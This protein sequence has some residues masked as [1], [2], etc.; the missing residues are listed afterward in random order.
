MAYIDPNGREGQGISTDSDGDLMIN[1]YGYGQSEGGFPVINGRRL[2]DK[3]AMWA[4]SQVDGRFLKARN[5]A[6]MATARAVWARRQ[7]ISAA[8][9]QG[10]NGSFFGRESMTRLDVGI[11][12]DGALRLTNYDNG[13]AIATVPSNAAPTP[14]RTAA[15]A[16]ASGTGNS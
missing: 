5:P 4:V 10:P 14:A 2:P 6:D 9:G 7:E 8:L 15:P 1:H 3:Q 11:E 12:P 13:R 16:A